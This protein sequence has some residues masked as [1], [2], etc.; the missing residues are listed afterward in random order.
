MASFENKN[1]NSQLAFIRYL[2]DAQPWRKRHNP[3]NLLQ[4]KSSLYSFISK[5]FNVVVVLLYKKNIHQL[6]LYNNIPE[7]DLLAVL[8][9]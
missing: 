8:P 7:N 1:A 3:Y 4:L 2:L 9:T 5:Q 6:N